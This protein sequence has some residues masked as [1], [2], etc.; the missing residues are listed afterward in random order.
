MSVIYENKKKVRFLIGAAT[1]ECNQAL[2]GQQPDKFINPSMKKSKVHF[3]V[4]S[5][6][7]LMNDNIFS[8]K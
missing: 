1:A 2:S 5:Q 3:S 7:Q 4:F 6:E 8:R